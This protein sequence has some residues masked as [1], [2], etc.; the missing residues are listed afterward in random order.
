[1]RIAIVN[2][3]SLAQAVLQRLIESVPGYSVAWTAKDG[4]EAVRRA[5]ADLPDAILMDLL[6]PVMDGAEA[7]RRIMAATPCPILVV[8]SSVGGNYGKVYEALGAGGLDATQTP[9]FGPGGIVQGGQAILDRLAL[10]GQAQANARKAGAVSTG[11]STPA[12]TATA[13]THLTPLVAIGASTGGPEAIAQVLSSMGSKIPCPVVVIQHIAA[14][15]AVGLASWLQSRTGLLVAAAEEGT[16]PIAGHVYVA[17]SNDHLV[18]RPNRRFAYVPD[19]RT[20]PYRPSVDAFFESLGAAWPRPGVAVLLTGMG[21]D[22]ARGLARL[23]ALGWH[24]IAQ[25]KASCVVYGM[26][27]AAEELGATVEVLPLIRIGN[28]V[29]NWLKNC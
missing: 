17:V 4:A 11:L 20:C 16:E 10:L 13:G 22:G 14:D 7:T 1:M 15:F 26:P 27:R 23:K 2:D 21:S 25:D 18:L 28:A 9:T 8:T 12:S 24:T 5:A 3:L 6:M 29:M 19:P